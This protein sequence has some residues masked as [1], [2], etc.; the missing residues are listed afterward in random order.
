MKYDFLI[1][2]L[3]LTLMPDTAQA[4]IDPGAASMAIQATIAA[5]AGGAIALRRL[6]KSIIE[7]V[8]RIYKK[9]THH[10]N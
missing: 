9:I 7:T 4:Y 3:A 10:G 5:I 6:R 2:L 1:I 8:S